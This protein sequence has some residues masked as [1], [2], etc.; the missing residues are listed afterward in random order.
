M[1][2]VTVTFES[3]PGKADSLERLLL[4]QAQNSLQN[5]LACLRFDVARSIE[6]PNRFFL[7]EI[8]Q[9]A[10]AFAQHLTTAHFG[11]F[12]QQAGPLVDNK[13]VQTWALSY[14]GDE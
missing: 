6:N 5:E 2:V 11:N 7:F 4:K 10:A 14:Q 3:I 13:Q 12:D 1:F 8:Y 9:D